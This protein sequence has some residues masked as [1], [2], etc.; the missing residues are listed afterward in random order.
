MV[1]LGPS[2]VLLQT[3]VYSTETTTSTVGEELNVDLN[4]SDQMRRADFL[5]AQ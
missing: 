3:Q 4:D 1:A 5:H 2:I